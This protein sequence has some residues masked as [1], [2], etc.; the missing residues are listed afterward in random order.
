MDWG[1][2]ERQIPN[3]HLEGTVLVSEGDHVQYRGVSAVPLG[4][5]LQQISSELMYRH[6]RGIEDLI[7]QLSNRGELAPLGT[8]GIENSAPLSASQWVGSATLTEPAHKN[9]VACFQKYKNS[10]DPSFPQTSEDSGE[11]F[12]ESPF[13][14]V[15]DNGDVVDTLTALGGQF[16]EGADEL[17]R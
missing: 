5:M 9:I 8:N 7:R 11:L 3:L 12:Q 16:G 2:N 15:G 1:G 13:S 10:L 6:L 4:E 17:S 14:N